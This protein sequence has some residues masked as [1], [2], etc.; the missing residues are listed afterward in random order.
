MKKNKQPRGIR[1]NNPGNLKISDNRW[2]GKVSV[3]QN[4][5]GT[6][7]Q[8]DE[9]EFGVRA[10]A[11]LIKNYVYKFGVKDLHGIISRYAPSSENNVE[12][13]VQSVAKRAE[14]NPHDSAKSWMVNSE[15]FERLIDAMI[16]HENGK[17]V[18][19]SVIKKGIELI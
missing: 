8:F 12:A 4:T 19:M 1:N 2:D 18:S 16:Y 5:D 13:Y 6:F 9:M 14:I 3:S 7:E 17:R 11:K 10:M 15:D